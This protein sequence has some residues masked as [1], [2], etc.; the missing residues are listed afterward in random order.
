MS[1]PWEVSVVNPL[2]GPFTSVG[3]PSTDVVVEYDQDPTLSE[4]P[5]RSDPEDGPGTHY[6]DPSF[7][8]ELQKIVNFEVNFSLDETT[9]C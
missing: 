9:K 3:M 6:I 1:Y 5:A 4:G 7:R 8:D 2:P